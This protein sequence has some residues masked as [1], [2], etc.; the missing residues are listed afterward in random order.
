MGDDRAI[1]RFS[2]GKGGD[3]SSLYG[4][5]IV[6]H[7]GTDKGDGQWRCTKDMAHGPACIHIKAARRFLTQG[8]DEE[9]VEMDDMGETMGEGV[10]VC[11]LLLA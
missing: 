1:H 3:T 4:R 9:A 8:Q 6:T 10:D 2:V 7:D 11:E 5:V